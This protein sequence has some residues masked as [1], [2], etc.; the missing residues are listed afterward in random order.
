[1]IQRSHKDVQK[2]KKK[3]IRPRPGPIQEYQKQEYIWKS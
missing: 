3:K 1:M 2:M